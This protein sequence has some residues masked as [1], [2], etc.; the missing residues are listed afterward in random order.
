[1]IL[2]LKSRGEANAW[3][4]PF[5]PGGYV[6]DPWPSSPGFKCS[7]ALCVARAYLKIMYACRRLNTLSVTVSY[8]W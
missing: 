6:P 5:E 2:Y 4:L 3:P 8:I 7:A 1:M